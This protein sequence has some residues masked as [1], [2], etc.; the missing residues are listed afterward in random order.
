MVQ[1]SGQSDRERNVKITDAPLY[2]LS[3]QVVC[4]YVIEA[5]RTHVNQ[6]SILHVTSQLELVCD[7]LNSVDK[8]QNL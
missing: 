2:F 4:P 8:K 6:Y 5:S 7:K 1:L 3:Q